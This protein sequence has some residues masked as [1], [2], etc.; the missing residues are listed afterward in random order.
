MNLSNHYHWFAELSNT[1]G[2]P[3][4]EFAISPDWMTAWEWSH[5]CAIRSGVLPASSH[6]AAA[7]VMP[8]WNSQSGQPR[9]DGFQ[10]LF[11]GLD[12]NFGIIPLNFF[13][14]PV[15][16]LSNKLIERGTLSH[17]E[18]FTFRICAYTSQTFAAATNGDDDP[19]IEPISTPLPIRAGGLAAMQSGTT[20]VSGPATCADD[21]PVFIP[22][23]VLDEV[24]AQAR[25]VE[26]ETGGVLIG[27]L[28][29]DTNTGAL[30][31]SVNAFI[32]ARHTIA[33]RYSLKFT[34]DTWA[35]VDA[36]IALRNQGEIP[37]GWAH[38]HPFFCAQC[39][40][41]N[42]RL[43][44]MSRPF[45][46]DAD[47]IAHRTA[48]AKA[49]QVALLLSFV[50]EKEPHRDLFGWHQGMIKPRGF[51]I[52]PSSTNLNHQPDHIDQRGIN[53]DPAHG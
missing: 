6:C 12:R 18:L 4:G 19:S 11:D 43:C 44:S 33:D 40:Q 17:G 21:M 49:W 52:I 37:L 47:R 27:E 26:V 48:F 2:Q 14:T 5:L 38:H 34:A 39:P 9:V 32:P 31:S 46:S 29:R 1:S 35:D 50:G 20:A 53:N 41:E 42:R 16:R 45:F 25:G 24:E 10:V 7:T 51:S 23:Q 36:A 22:Q 3:I 8:V 13:D 15:N 28:H 30:F